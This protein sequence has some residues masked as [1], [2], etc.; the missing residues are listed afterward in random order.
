MSYFPVI[1]SFLIKFLF[2]KFLEFIQQCIILSV[3]APE[4]GISRQHPIERNNFTSFVLI[5][6]LHPYPD[7]FR[8]SFFHY[9]I[10]KL[11]ITCSLHF[12][13]IH[14]HSFVSYDII[15]QIMNII[16]YYIIT[17]VTTYYSRII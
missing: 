4:K 17:K 10:T 12:V 15:S 13:Y 8:F 5:T 2:C 6:D 11:G 16:D 1:S 7:T 3:S 9:T 14:Y